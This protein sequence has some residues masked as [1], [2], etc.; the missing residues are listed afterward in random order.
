MATDK[1]EVEL[2]IKANN[3]SSK[4]LKEVTAAIDNLSDSLD[5]Q[6]E[7]A[8]KGET[9]L[10]ELTGSYKKLED[11]GKALISQQALIDRFNQVSIA[12]QS[13]SDKARQARMS[14]N[15][16]ASEQSNYSKVTKEQDAQLLKLSKSA[17]A[18]DR[19]LA[20]QKSTLAT[21][22]TELERAG[23]DTANLTN[24]QERLVASAQKVAAA[25]AKA[26]SA[27]DTF[28]PVKQPAAVEN[29][30]E[31]NGR[32]TL[33]LLQRIRGEVLAL[34]AAYVGL[35]G[36]IQGAGAALEALKTDQQIH[37]KLLVV[38]GGDA[39]A[40]ADEYQYLR[41]QAD[42]L[43]I[44]L[45]S[46][47]KQYSSFAIA[48]KQANMNTKD[49]R[50]VFEKVAEAGRVMHLSEDDLNR[51]FLSIQQM[52]SKGV[53]QAEELK[54]QL[55]DVIPGAVGLMAKGMNSSVEEF[56]K[57][58]AAGQVKAKDG[59][60]ALARAMN[61]EFAKGLDGATGGVQAQEERFKTALFEFR[62][63]IANAGFAD[64]YGELL[65]KLSD[66][67]Q[68]EDG[69]KFA[70]DIGEAFKA[71]ADALSF[72]IDN[73]ETFKTIAEALVGMYLAKQFFNMMV[74]AAAFKD[75]MKLMNA[76][77]STATGLMAN[78]QKAF[79]LFQSFIAGWEIGKILSDKFEVVRQLGV[80]MVI[81]FEELWT[82]IKFGAQ[83]AWES[84]ATSWQDVSA[85]LINHMTS[86]FRTILELFQK[87]ARSVG[88][89]SVADS[90]GKALDAMTAKHTDAA[91]AK[92]A[93]LRADMQKELQKI[94]DIGYDMFQDASDASRAAAAKRPAKATPQATQESDP[95]AKPM[96][97]GSEKELEKYKAKYESIVGE[98][99]AIEAQTQRK[100]KDSLDARLQAIDDQYAKL[101]RK[102]KELGGKGADELQARLTKDIAALKAQ[103][104]EN[105][106]KEQG[107]RAEAVAK[108]FAEIETKLGKSS[109]VGDLDMRLKAIDDSYKSLYTDIGALDE[110]HKGNL[111]A[112][113]TAY[114]EQLKALE[115]QKYY[116]DQLAAQQK[117]MNELVSTRDDQIKTINDEVRAG[118]LTEAQGREKI[119]QIVEATQPAI[120]AAAQD[121]ITFAESLRGLVDDAKLDQFIAKMQLAQT[122]AKGVKTELYSAAQANQD[123]ASGITNWIDQAAQGFGEAI[124]GA[125]T[126]GEAVRGA[127]RA[128]LSFAAD[129]LKKIALMIIQQIIL[130]SLQNSSIG[131][132]IG[133]GVAAATKHEGGVMGS[134]SGNRTRSAPVSWFA[135]APRYHTGGV[136]GLAP[137]EYPA[138]L[139]KNEEVLTT[140][141]PRNVLNGGLNSGQPATPVVQDVK[142]INTIDSGSFVSEGLSTPE[143]TRAI[144]NFV[145]ANRS[146]FK[147]LIGG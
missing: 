67:F 98:I 138:I 11:A 38:T 110:K 66:F 142:V 97:G 95:N 3:L 146:Q 16:L 59:V 9:R 41:E 42:R 18:A 88:A 46:L 112:Q 76:Q 2:I 120:E 39:K 31:S 101:F 121:S 79:L 22:S 107:D 64:A 55:G 123:L 71:V 35:Q 70:K 65:G 8:K 84:I 103:V 52:V 147:Q 75:E 91:R 77:L 23:I 57:K 137:D 53:V 119:K 48:A 127:G 61:E 54:G 113:L 99:E 83:I 25:H 141:D 12:V 115:T 15:A 17:D 24:S 144:F 69:A 6:V 32:T 72:V 131:A 81:G 82:R 136:A 125:K 5:K 21:L 20:R 126:F 94:R 34:T 29:P 13:A 143:G 134:Y 80:S 118:L 93:Q 56:M 132:S 60:I 87:A 111:D 105:F 19:A 104:S 73:L 140:N 85:V 37:A 139:K 133:A 63:Q 135:N 96:F 100:N 49:M 36:A 78:M 10:S 28:A 58:M 109:L 33:S 114:L 102:I 30:F 122:S 47:A 128:F 45:P 26:G 50:F 129:F 43:G 108:R 62:K 68:S 51:A 106:A 116:Q 89:D 1:R 40:A 14:F 27:I 92:V 90:I 86:T 130:N 44:S 117:T 145:R 124:A 74:A 4:Q 7:S